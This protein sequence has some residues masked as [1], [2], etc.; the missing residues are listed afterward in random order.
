M[1]HDRNKAA[2]NPRLLR[3]A[4]SQGS[5]GEFATK[6]GDAKLPTRNPRFLISHGL[7]EKNAKLKERR[8]HVCK[9]YLIVG[10][11]GS[12]AASNYEMANY[13]GESEH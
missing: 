3:W 13:S 9:E 10:L 8:S 4:I 5:S 2:C 7:S 11:A 6:Y 12:M 1:P